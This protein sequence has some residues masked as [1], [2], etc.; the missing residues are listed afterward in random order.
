M[1]YLLKISDVLVNI[2]A[3]DIWAKKKKKSEVEAF[4][5]FGI[6]CCQKLRDRGLER[7]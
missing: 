7:C 5:R 6:C 3:K 1:W 4:S 2:K